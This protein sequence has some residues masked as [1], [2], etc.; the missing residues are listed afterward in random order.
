MTTS[1]VLVGLCLGVVTGFGLAILQRGALS[2]PRRP[3][4]VLLAVALVA[5]LISTPLLPV[6]VFHK[7]VADPPGETERFHEAYVVDASGEELELPVALY[8]PVSPIAYVGILATTDGE[9]RYDAART[10]FEAARDHRGAVASRDPVD[11]AVGLVAPPEPL[12]GDRWTAAELDEYDRFVGLR[13]YEAT[14]H[15]VVPA[16]EPD[17]R[18]TDRHVVASFLFDPTERT[19]TN[20]TAPRPTIQRDHVP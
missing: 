4:Q 20:D 15:T 18:V 1:L 3:A 12:L 6:P 19:E 16:R 17:Y 9:R 10:L 13:V 7:Y 2:N 5:N 14:A 8:P 11:R